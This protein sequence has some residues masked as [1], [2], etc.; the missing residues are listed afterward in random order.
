MYIHNLDLVIIF[1]KDYY[2]NYYI[3]II[4]IR[5]CIYYNH[6]SW[7]QLIAERDKDIYREKEREKGRGRGSYGGYSLT[8]LWTKHTLKIF[9]YN[10]HGAYIMFMEKTHR[11]GFFIIT[12]CY[13][14][15]LTLM[16]WKCA[17]DYIEKYNFALLLANE[18][19]KRFAQ[20]R[21]GMTQQH[22][23]HSGS[24]WRDA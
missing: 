18:I 20:I 19:N 14:I 7:L 21:S 12:S 8:G 4:H 2:Y 23:R 6:S 1:S 22:R 9:L 13:R 16:S 3:I 5:T 15:L 10:M 24:L 17:T 11:N